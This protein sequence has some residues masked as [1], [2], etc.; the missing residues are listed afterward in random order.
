MCE[1]LSSINGPIP[2]HPMFLK[3]TTGS[4][5]SAR[6]NELGVGPSKV[7]GPIVSDFSVTERGPVDYSIN[8]RVRG[9]GKT[10]FLA[11]KNGTGV[12]MLIELQG[13]SISPRTFKIRDKPKNYI[14]SNTHKIRELMKKAKEREAQ[15]EFKLA[16]KNAPIKVTEKYKDVQSKVKENLQKEPLAP[17]DSNKEFLRAHSKTGQISRPQSARPSTAG[18]TKTNRSTSSKDDIDFVRQNR[19][20][21][22]EPRMKRAPSMEMLKNVQEKLNK[23]MEKYNEKIKGKIPNY[24]EQRKEYIKKSTDEYVKNLPDPEQPPGHRKLSDDE[25]VGTLNLLQ[26]THKKLLS[27][28][29]SLPIRNDTFRIQTTKSEMEKR[30]I[31]IDEAIKIFSKPKVFVKVES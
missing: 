23:D 15:K 19:E 14:A 18:S 22:K 9:V 21:A 20:L 31:Q 25:R 3:E 4:G 12:A 26:E 2:P 17:R 29:N 24:L 28:L 13:R 6:S 27:E 8:P 5:M 11:N 1:G 7:T 16:E 10:N 30:L